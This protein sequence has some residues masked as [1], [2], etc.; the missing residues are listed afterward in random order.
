MYKTRPSSR[1]QL[2]YIFQ[3]SYYSEIWQVVAEGIHEHTDYGNMMSAPRRKV[4]Q[5]IL[6]AWSQQPK[7][8]IAKVI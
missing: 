7:V 2:K 6:E 1:C 5:W 8:I 4:V 3:G